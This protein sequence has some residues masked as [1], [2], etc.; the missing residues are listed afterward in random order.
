LYDDRTK[1]QI[2]IRYL[3]SKARLY[4][5]EYPFKEDFN[6]S[7]RAYYTN[8]CQLI[9]VLVRDVAHDHRDVSIS[10]GRLSQHTLEPDVIKLFALYLPTQKEEWQTKK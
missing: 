7:L 6:A 3:Q 1:R 8:N 5:E 10:Y 9:G 2:I 4:A